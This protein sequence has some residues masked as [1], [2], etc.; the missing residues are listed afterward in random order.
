M[1][2]ANKKRG[3]TSTTNGSGTNGTSTNGSVSGCTDP[4]ALNYSASATIDDGSCV[5]AVLGCCD[6]Q[7]SNYDSTC[8]GDPNC[9]CSYQACN[10]TTGRT[11]CCDAMATEYD[12]TCLGDPL[13]S[14]DASLCLT[15]ITMGSRTACCQAGA[16][17]Y[18]STCVND[19]YCSCDNTIC[20]SQPQAHTCYTDCIG[21]GFQSA[22]TTLPC[23]SGAMSNYPNINAPYCATTQART[24]GVRNL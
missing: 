16:P 3:A 7:A 18:D 4:T 6:N 11:A 21:T 23:G 5:S 24:G 20:N 8:D 10:F 2:T 15:T 14:C 13:C 12:A 22:V 19:P 1:Q 17:N 9:Q